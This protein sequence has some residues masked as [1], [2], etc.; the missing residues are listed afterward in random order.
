[1]SL[2]CWYRNPNRDSSQVKGRTH[3]QLLDNASGTL[4]RGS[5]EGEHRLIALFIYIVISNQDPI[6]SLSLGS[7]DAGVLYLT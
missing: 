1:M 5:L 2:A 7:R 6:Y 3:G 4:N